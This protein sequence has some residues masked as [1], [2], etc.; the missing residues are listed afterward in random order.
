MCHI[1]ST[2]ATLALWRQVGAIV[3]APTRELISLKV[4]VK[5]FC[6]SQFPHKSVNL[7]FIITNT[8]DELTNLCGNR[9]L[10]NALMQI[11]SLKSICKSQFPHKSV[12]VSSI[13]TNIKTNLTNLCGNRLLQNDF[14][15]TFCEIKTGADQST[16]WS[17]NNPEKG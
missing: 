15:N 17:R 2:A 13:M 7:C 14:I 5:S 6:R 11:L 16:V 8:K 9:L 10:Q 12:N 4:F 3:I 1:R